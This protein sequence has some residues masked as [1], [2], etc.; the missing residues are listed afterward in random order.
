LRYAFVVR[1]RRPFFPP[2]VL[3]AVLVVSMGLAGCESSGVSRTVQIGERPTWNAGDSWT[4]RGRGPS[5]TFNVTRK[6]LRE[7]V[8]EG[9]EAYEVDAG[10][11]HYWYTKQLGYLART[12][13]DETTR[14][15]RPPE[16]WQWPIQVGKQWS[17]IV[18]WIDRTDTQQ[19]TY[20]LTS[21]WTVEA[22]EEVKTP[23]GTF[24]AF[25][26]TRRE[27]ESGASQEL[28]YSP[29]VKSWIKIRGA[30][31]ADGNYEEELTSFTLR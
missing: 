9:R 14:L 6:V 26:V 27:I 20:T 16:D 1:L 24:K 17:A 31:T 7:G 19:Q 10:G 5:G 28:W 4:Y 2:V 29:E 30:N 22:Y 8:F 15:A 18:A 21:V 25:K 3:L 12:K 23:A 13:G 11:T